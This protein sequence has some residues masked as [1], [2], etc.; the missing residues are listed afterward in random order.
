M[1]VLL[2]ITAVL[3]LIIGIVCNI[4]VDLFCRAENGNAEAYGQNKSKFNVLESLP[5]YLAVRHPSKADSL[6]SM[7]NI[8]QPVLMTILYGFAALSFGY[9]AAFVRAITLITAVSVSAFTDIRANIIDN[10][11]LIAAAVLG[12]I[13][14]FAFNDSVWWHMLLGGVAGGILLFV[15]NLL[16]VL[17]TGNI[18]FGG[19]DIKMMA[20]CGL[21]LGWKLTL[22]AEIAGIIFGA[23]IALVM[24]S[25]GKAKK[26]GYIPFGPAL[27][28]GCIAA[29]FFGERL[30]LWYGSMMG[31][32]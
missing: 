31:L 2:A 7:L 25:R 14:M 1:S 29:L 30:L 12:A 22:F 32:I 17:F 3:G 16:S 26:E 8:T 4:L 15:L 28:L 27:A 13:F 6:R 24:L 10:R 9:S 5:F 11:P 18:G 19:G 21:L 23:V 20:A